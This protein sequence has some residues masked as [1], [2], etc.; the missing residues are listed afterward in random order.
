MHGPPTPDRAD[1]IAHNTRPNPNTRSQPT[2]ASAERLCR[3]GLTASGPM[4]QW[5]RH[6]PTEPGIAGLSPAGVIILGSHSSRAPKHIGRPTRVAAPARNI[7]TTFTTARRLEEASRKRHRGDSNPCGHSLMDF[8]SISLPA[9]T[10]CHCL[11]SPWPGLMPELRGAFLSWLGPPRAAH[12]SAGV[13]RAR[14]RLWQ[15][16]NPLYYGC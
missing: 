2:L 3:R 16:R 12:G 9:W 14:P 1:T 11:G 13:R 15:L 7:H 10:P 6:R 8:E 5:I 4:V